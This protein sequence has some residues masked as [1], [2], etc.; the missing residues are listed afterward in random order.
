MIKLRDLFQWNVITQNGSIAYEWIAFERKKSSSRTLTEVAPLLSVLW[1]SFLLSFFASL[2]FWFYSRFIHHFSFAAAAFR[3]ENSFYMKFYMW[4]D[5]N[6]KRVNHSSCEL[7]DLICN[8][9]SCA[10]HMWINFRSLSLRD[11]H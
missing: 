7:W 5:H 3:E 9:N 4:Y 8:C 6:I 10:L 2:F 11:I 1:G